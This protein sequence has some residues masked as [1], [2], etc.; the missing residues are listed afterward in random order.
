QAAAGSEGVLISDKG[1]V[2]SGLINV[3]SR[4]QIYFKD[5]NVFDIQDNPGGG[6]KFRIRI[7]DGNA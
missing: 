7:E 6:T 2:S 3:I 5:N 4:L 1:H